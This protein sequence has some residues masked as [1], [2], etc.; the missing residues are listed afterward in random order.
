MPG[1]YVGGAHDN[2]VIGNHIGTDV[3]GSFAV[4]NSHSGVRAREAESN[5]IGG[6][7]SGEGNVIAGN[8]RNQ[9]SVVQSLDTRIV[10]NSDGTDFSMAFG[11]EN[12][13]EGVFVVQGNNT[14]TGGPG[15]HEGNLI[16]SAR[17]A[18]P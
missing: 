9:I 3:T 2:G 16:T 5:I 10:G 1:T 8:T 17:F 13:E 18:V 6:S 15:S 11:M 12:G 14:L 7:A 4:P